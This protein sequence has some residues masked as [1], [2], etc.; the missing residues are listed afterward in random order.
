MIVGTLYILKKSALMVF[1][2]DFA[3]SVQRDEDGFTCPIF[4]FHGIF[5]VVAFTLNLFTNMWHL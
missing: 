1:F 3:I 2:Q 5:D 4:S